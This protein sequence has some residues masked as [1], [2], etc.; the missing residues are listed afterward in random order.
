MFIQ[1]YKDNNRT[2]IWKYWKLFPEISEENMITLNEGNTKISEIDG[3]FFKHEYDNPTGSVKDR[4][5]CFQMAVLKSKGIKNACISSSGNAAISAAKYAWLTGINL[6]VFVSVNIHPEK[7]ARLKIENINIVKSLRPVSDA[8]KFSKAENA[9]NLR[10]STDENAIYGFSTISFE[11]AEQIPDA[12]AVFF[13][14]SSATTLCGAAYGFDEIQKNIAIH[15]VQT[16]KINSIS[17]D[18]DNNWKMSNK[19]LADAIVARFT[20]RKS[21]ALEYI[22]KNKGYGWV[23]SDDEIKVADDWLNKQNIICSYEG[24]V[25]LSGLFKAKK[26]GYEYRK[27]VILL[28]GRRY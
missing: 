28:T 19:S 10:Q 22:K 16:E 2:G 24:A 13:P 14:V 7:L 4:G 8:I 20:P 26:H 23:I 3:I 18:F 21:D 12:D 15:C 6:T 11:L 9:F 25:S 5:I 17:S 27:P 1:Q